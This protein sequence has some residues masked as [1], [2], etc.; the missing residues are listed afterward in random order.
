MSVATFSFFLSFCFCCFH[1]FSYGSVL[2]RHN[3]RRPSCLDAACRVCLRYLPTGSHVHRFQTTAASLQHAPPVFTNVARASCACAALAPRLRCAAE[4]GSL[5]VGSS[6][7][8][9]TLARGVR[10]L[11]GGP[12]W[13]FRS[14]KHNGRSSRGRPLEA[15]RMDE[16]HVAI[17]HLSARLLL[18]W[19]YNLP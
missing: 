4:V 15:L 1:T 7:G 12:R 6:A 18:F 10:G 5:L 16:V 3:E 11:K 13:L 19:Y 2:L 9:S 17:E 8:R 14:W